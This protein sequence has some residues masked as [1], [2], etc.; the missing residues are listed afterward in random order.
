MPTQRSRLP[1]I[2]A[3]LPDFGLAALFL[4]TW[5][6]PATVG[7]H[8]IGTLLLVMLLEFI[9]VH[10]AG[11][12]GAAAV[13][14]G[15]RA[16]RLTWILGLGAF[17]TLF[18]GAF[19]AAFGVWWPLGAF[20]ALV[21]N[22]LLGALLGQVP[23]DEAKLFIMRG[24]AVGV[25]AYLGAVFATVLAPVPELGIDAGVRAAANL[26]G[27]GLWI[28]EPQRAIAAG[29]LYFAALGLSE[30]IDHGWLPMT[31]QE[32]GAARSPHA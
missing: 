22:R 27:G 16:Q 12:M 18:V 14:D 19:A 8:R 4:V 25:I 15:T 32:R 5:I 2:I 24:W 13:G 11:F 23:S 31:G 9:V 6:S 21:L 30:L 20:W 29:V 26:P 1:A 7:A 3:A 10:S 17:Y 28:D